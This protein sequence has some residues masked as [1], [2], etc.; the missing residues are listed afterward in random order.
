MQIKKFYEETNSNY[1]SALSIM[2]ND[3][4]IERMIRKFMEQNSFNAI[5]DAYEK[6]NIRD[7][8]ALSHSFKGVTGNLALTGLY[9]IASDLTEATRNK[10]EA[11]IADY[12]EKLK[13]EYQLI[14]EK[15]DLLSK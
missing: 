2:M 3:M 12:I 6:N 10:E 11:D 7:V 8:F 13:T 14:Q 9:N 5:I 15:F 1:N 4:L